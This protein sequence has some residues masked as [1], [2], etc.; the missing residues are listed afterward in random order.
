MYT[1][2]ILMKRLMVTLGG[3][4]A[5]N[6]FYGRNEVS[7]GAMQDLKQANQLAKQMITD[8]GMGNKLEVFSSVSS[9]SMVSPHSEYIFSTLEKE[10]LQLV[11]QAYQDVI[12]LLSHNKEL[13]EKLKSQL[14]LNK[15]LDKNDITQLK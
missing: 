1:K 11:N 12:Q 13:F 10:S 3:K 15:F 6:I 9:P 7:L 4:A 5:E 2:N 14:L 8:F